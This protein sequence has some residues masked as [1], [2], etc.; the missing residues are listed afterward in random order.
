M[1]LCSQFPVMVNVIEYNPVR[2]LD[3]E[4]SSTDRINQF[5][6]EVLKH[7]IMITVRRSRGKTLMLH[8]VSWLIWKY[9]I[10]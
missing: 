5:A 8:V 4:K 9:E 6:K 10:L 3:F 7:G 2:G 1:R